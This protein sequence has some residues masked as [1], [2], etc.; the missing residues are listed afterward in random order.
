ARH[1]AR[2]PGALLPAGRRAPP[3]QGGGAL[4][5]VVR[6]PEPG[7]AEPGTV[8]VAAGRHLLPQ[9]AHLPGPARP[10]AGAGPVPPARPR[11][12]VPAA[13]ALGEPDQPHR[14]LRAGPPQ[15]GPGVPEAARG[16]A[17]GRRA[18]VKRDAIS[19]L[20]VDDSA[21]NRREIAELLADLSDIEIVGTA[22]DGE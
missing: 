10:P 9:R 4:A 20:V 2:L 6:A 5:G 3:A 11:G 16:R 15:D 7:R 8:G 21:H 18:A 13:R 12:R 14:R 22:S 19:V 1:A 17:P